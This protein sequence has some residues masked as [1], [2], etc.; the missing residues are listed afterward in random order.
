MHFDASVIVLQ[1]NGWP[2]NRNWSNRWVPRDSHPSS[3]S[4][5]VKENV[6][7]SATR[8]EISQWFSHTT[9]A[10]PHLRCSAVT[11]RCYSN[12]PRHQQCHRQTSQKEAEVSLLDG[13]G[14][15]LKKWALLRK[16]PVVT[17]RAMMYS[18][19][20]T[21]KFKSS[22]LSQV[23]PVES[24]VKTACLCVCVCV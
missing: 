7:I 3:N 9:Q 10:P 14:S 21:L 20:E 6:I 2:L 22:T 11:H 23:M 13:V 8:K 1:S 18:W 4:H 16:I 17:V 5:S 19:Q 15:V 12:Q 24:H